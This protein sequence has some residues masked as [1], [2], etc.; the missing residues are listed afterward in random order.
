MPWILG[1]IAFVM[2]L[3]LGAA[4]LIFI[5]VSNA[6]SEPDAPEASASADLESGPRLE[7]PTAAAPVSSATVKPTAAPPPARPPP[8]FNLPVIPAPSTPVVLGAFPR[9]R[10]TN[11]LDRVTAG[12]A[13][14]KRAGDPTG[15]GSIRVDFEPDGR[16]GTSLARPFAGTSTGSCVSARFLAI[17]VGAFVGT[18]QQIQ[19]TFAIPPDPSSG[20]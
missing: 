9:A 2:L 14:C 15:A 18:T 11:E 13:S 3:G 10:A 17:K 1:G 12:L 4:V 6:D 19:R 16:V 5:A 20:F 8:T 7:V